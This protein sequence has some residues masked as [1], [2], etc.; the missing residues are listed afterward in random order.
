MLFENIAGSIAFITSVVG[1]FPQVFKAIQ[2]KS[3]QD[4]SMMMLINYFICSA[5]WIIYGG[6][7]SSG[8]VLFSNVIGLLG[9]VLLI[10]LK[11]NYDRKEKVHS[12]FAIQTD[13]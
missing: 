5:A 12:S 11:I 6:Y 13:S 4:V 10:F 9:S 2:T 8:F 7:V 3:T 1:L